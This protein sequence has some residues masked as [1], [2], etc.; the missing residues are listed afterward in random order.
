[1]IY[2]FAGLTRIALI[3]EFCE[4]SLFFLIELDLC[5]RL[6]FFFHTIEKNIFRKQ[7]C[8]KIHGPIHVF[9]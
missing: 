2:E 3:Y 9:G 4:L 1:M 8:Y 6:C 7:L 5:Y